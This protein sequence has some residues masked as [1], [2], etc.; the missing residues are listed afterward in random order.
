MFICTLTVGSLLRLNSNFPF[1]LLCRCSRDAFC[2]SEVVS[3]LACCQQDHP[4]GAAG[5]RLLLESKLLHPFL[6]EMGGFSSCSREWKPTMQLWLC[7]WLCPT[8]V[9]HTAPPHQQACWG[10][11]PASALPAHLLCGGSVHVSV[12]HCTLFPQNRAAPLLHF[13]ATAVGGRGQTRSF[14][15]PCLLQQ[16]IRPACIWLSGELHGAMGAARTGWWGAG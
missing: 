14:R 16:L 3:G 5:S 2:S 10:A 15:D 12:L 4:W 13:I 6:S 8:A 7:A 9:G 11:P 1:H